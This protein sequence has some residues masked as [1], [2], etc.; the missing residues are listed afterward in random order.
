[1]TQHVRHIGNNLVYYV[2]SNRMRIH[3][4]D[5]P[6]VIR[7]FE[8]FTHVAVASDAIAGWSTTLVEAGAGET[9]VTRPD[10][11]G[12][13]ILITADAADNDGANLQVTTGE[14]FIPASAT[15]LLHFGCR[16]K[17]S[18]ATQ[19]DFIVGLCIT[20]TDLLGGM[21][22]GIY[23]EKL[24]GGT[25]ISFTTEKN[26][27][28]TQSDSLATFAANTYV[29]L[30]WTFAAGSVYA[31]IDGVLVA[32]HTANIPDD[33][34]LTP[35]IQFLAGTTGGMTCAVDWIKAIQIGR[36]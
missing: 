11:Q 8:D 23:F 5:G 17:A 15:S 2:G 30:E 3:D 22:D 29:Q 10:T 31:F 7:F 4:A 20:D 18:E 9:T 1:M 13:A 21:T 14:S 27:T 36:A 35:S 24:D 6:D 32:T 19:S 12:G 28:E 26:S 16:I 34:L 33:E 25:G